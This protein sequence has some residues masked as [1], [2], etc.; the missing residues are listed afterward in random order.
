MAALFLVPSAPAA[1]AGL[2]GTPVG[3][4]RTDL[5]FG[6]GQIVHVQHSYTRQGELCHRAD[7]VGALGLGKGTWRPTGHHSFSYQVVER[8]YDDAG[9][10]FGRAEMS[11]DAVVS[12]RVFRALHVSRVFDQDG[13]FLGESQGEIVFTRVHGGNPEC[14]EEP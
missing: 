11:G 7:A 13:A 12:G 4:W 6:G 1:L 8:F 3:F 9:S 5:D 2:G 10:Y 14:V